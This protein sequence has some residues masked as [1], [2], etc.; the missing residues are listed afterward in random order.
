M[1]TTVAFTLLDSNPTFW[2]CTFHLATTLSIIME[3]LNKMTVTFMHLP[4]GLTWALVYTTFIWLAVWLG[5]V[6]QWPYVFLDTS[7]PLC[8]LWY[9]GLVVC[10]IFY[11][12]LFAAVSQRKMKYHEAYLRTLEENKQTSIHTDLLGAKDNTHRIHR[13]GYGGEE[14]A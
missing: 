5:A 11:Y 14:I 10:F 4:F 13:G 6:S 12:C 2:N 7:S 3:S 1:V 8:F 9:S